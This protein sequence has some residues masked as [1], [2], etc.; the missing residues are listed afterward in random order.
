MPN[1]SAAFHAVALVAAARSALQTAW[2]IG[3][4]RAGRD[5]SEQEPEA[6]VR[7]D[8]GALRATLADDVVRLRLR[9]AVGAPAGEAA[10]LAQAFEDRT[11][12]DDLGRTLA[13]VHQKLLSL[14]PAV[15]E[16]VVEDARQLATEARRRAVADTYDVG[17]GR[18]AAR[19]SDL[20]DRLA[21]ALDESV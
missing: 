17:L 16:A 21:E 1:D 8:L 19:V 4:R 12:L 13:L 18:V 7:D 2:R 11:R 15:A 20:C 10:A 14:Y 6:A 9:A 5:A 3:E